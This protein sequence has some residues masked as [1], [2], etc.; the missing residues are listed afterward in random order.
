MVEA[1]DDTTIKLADFGFAK[2]VTKPYCLR[3]LCGTAQYVAPEVLDLQS[4]GYDCR[5]DMWSVGVVVYILLGGYA[6]FEGPVQ[7]LARA[8]CNADYCF[9]DK[10][11]S[12][13]SD[14]AKG[15]ISSLLEVDI[16]RR[17][18]A[19]AALQCPWMT[20][21]EESL[22]AKDLSGAQEKL[23]QTKQAQEKLLQTKQ[24]ET[25]ITATPGL[26]KND[27]I[28]VFYSTMIDQNADAN[29]K[30]MLENRIKMRTEIDEVKEEDM[31]TVAGVIDDSSSGKPFQRLYRLG[32]IIEE[33][34]FIPTHEAKHKQSKII[35]AV[36]RIERADLHPTDAVALQDEISCLQMVCDCPNIIALEDVFEEPDYTYMIF[37][38]LRGGPLIDRIIKRRH[39]TERDARTLIKGVLLGIE[40]CHNRRIA[41]R[42]LKTESLVCVSRESDV[43][44]KITDFGFAKRVLYPNSLQTQCGTEG[45]VAPEILEHRPAYD[46]QCDMWSLGVVLYIL[47]GGY[48]PFRGEGEAVMRMIR[49]GEFKFHKRYWSDVSEDAKILIARML[50]VNPIARITATG[51]LQSDWVS[52]TAAEMLTYTSTGVNPNEL[53]DEAKTKVK[54][55]VKT[56]IA[57][58][59]LGDS[60]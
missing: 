55:V 49:Y 6:P 48:R 54:S 27:S 59:K 12:E 13:I 31:M 19:E 17:L 44:V 51:A 14:A 2:K 28:N 4:G 36:K 60:S 34:D 42:N 39:Y 38:R 58:K 30:Q 56:I 53:K 26:T 9:H 35:Y 40:H 18:T 52:M 23:Q 41:I 16:E 15:M 47:I 20:I 43:D 32:K 10:Y 1:D 29:A 45:Y 57:S 3:T 22:G 8:I 33:G 46:V 37:E 21:E 5:A 25:T 11:W 50:T 7:E 24:A